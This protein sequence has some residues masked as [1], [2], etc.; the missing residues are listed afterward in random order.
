MDTSGVIVDEVIDPIQL[1]RIEAV[2]RGFLYQ[3]L[4]AVACLINLASQSTGKVAVERDEDI[5][6]SDNGEIV[7]IQVKT[8]TKQLIFSDIKKSL[9]LFDQLRDKYSKSSPGES[10]K[11]AVVSNVC[12]GPELATS[13]KASNWPNDVSIIWPGCSQNINS[14]A[15]PAW[16]S[17]SEA[18]NWCI[19]V[20]KDLPLT[21]L[22]PD[23]LVWKL[24]ARVQYACTGEDEDR[25]DHIFNRNDLPN[26]FEQFAEQLQEF[27]SVPT[28][29]KPQQNEPDLISTE[30]VRLMIGFS[31]AG[32]TVWASWQA[33]HC[34]AP[35]IYFDVAGLPGN[36][37]AGSL[38]RELA[39]RF[40]GSGTH[41]AVQL[42]AT[43]GIE[44]L[45]ALNKKINLPEL[46]LVVIDNIHRIDVEEM[47]NIVATCSRVKLILLA[48]PWEE[49]RRLEALLG[50]KSEQLNGWD[51]DTIASVFAEKGANISP[52]AARRWRILTSGMPLF[53]KNAAFLCLNFYDGDATSFANEVEKRDHAEELSQET[54]LRMTTSTLPGDEAAVIAALSLSTVPLSNPDINE[55]LKS[56]P[57]SLLQPNVVLRSLQKKG[58]VQ[59][60]SNGSRKLHDAL[61][62]SGSALLSKFSVEETLSLQI[63]LR[64][65]LLR[66]FLTKKDL[67]LFGAWMRLLPPTGHI[68]T[69]VD[70]ATMEYFHESGE[71]S[72][73]KAILIETANS[74]E[75]EAEMRFWTLD[76]L[77]F[78]ELQKG[79]KLHL[80]EE[81]VDRMVVLLQKENLG[82][83]ERVA[84]VMKQMLCYSGLKKDRAKVDVVFRENNN[85]WKNDP[86]LSRLARYNYAVALYHSGYIED[87]LPIAEKLYLEYYKVL[88]LKPANIIGANTKEIISL[89]PGEYSDYQ[90]DV[91][92]LADCLNLTA[93]CLRAIGQYPGLTE[94]HAA[95]FYAAS[96]SPRSAMKSAQD[97]ADDFIAIGDIVG[98]R[99]IME[100][101]VL[102]LLEHYELISNTM[103][104]QGQY[105]VIL[106]YCG[107]YNKA[108]N[109]MKTLN[110][111]VGNL[112]PAHQEGFAKQRQFIEEIAEGKVP[113]LSL[114]EDFE[115]KV[116][117]IRQKFQTKVGRNAKC[118][119]GSGEKYKKCCLN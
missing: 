15:P 33:Q 81:Y 85:L 9:N 17:L 108:R 50:I 115:A 55:Y 57:T 25:H 29:F 12:P 97:A 107:E 34:S 75:I 82:N 5:E 87:V 76:A 73:L 54:I 77:A 96:N 23:T 70:I 118:P 36:A 18:F 91:K 41:G 117:K 56:L 102:P 30:P 16:R 40:L 93:K 38:A 3:H 24:A 64:D 119:C 84:V 78:W 83:R 99:Q 21:T 111:Y 74:T 109:L 52:E 69:L 51:E 2:H 89:L 101:Q 103:D 10:V 45:Q 22:S 6:I 31:G 67:S 100:S 58:L 48:Q 112:S 72:D 44:L 95:K 94:I 71:P 39:A 20:A 88:R 42:P 80:A 65:I 62:I 53:V 90:D 61:R 86:S 104:A 92:H 27:P 32:K 13:F 110:S 59:I 46:P 98:A 28:D 19:A 47:R 79:E 1:K 35:A 26:L 43:S 63:K 105:A 68:E 14:V 11:F 114:P 60:F 7:F 66:S 8:R 37:L 4:Y 113:L 106:A 116:E 49:G